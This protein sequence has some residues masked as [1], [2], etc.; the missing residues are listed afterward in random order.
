MTAA[1]LIACPTCMKAIGEIVIV[2]GQDW[3]LLNGVIVRALHGVCSTCGTE[4]HY[5]AS[6][7]MLSV[8]I[9][10]VVVLREEG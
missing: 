6:D 3:L 1:T 8:L 9:Q 7:K 10:S 2:T 5:S 4:I